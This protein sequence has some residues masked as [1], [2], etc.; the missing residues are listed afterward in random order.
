M[1]VQRRH[2][3]Q[4]RPRHAE[5]VPTPRITVPVARIFNPGELDLDDLAE[6]IR[7]LLGTASPAQIG[8]CSR[9]R[10]ELL[11]FPHRVTHVVEAK[12]H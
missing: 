10:P 1:T 9:P 4:N 5:S 6:A 8:P 12:T 7:S 11:S 2:A 3:T